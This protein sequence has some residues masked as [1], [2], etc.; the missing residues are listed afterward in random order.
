M[1]DPSLKYYPNYY[2]WECLYSEFHKKLVRFVSY[3]SSKSKVKV[4]EM[5]SIKEIGWIAVSKVRRPT[6]EDF[7]NST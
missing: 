1:N 5:D 3:N 4:A 6:R 2:K 7:Q